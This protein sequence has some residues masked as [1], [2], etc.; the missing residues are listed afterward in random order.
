[1]ILVQFFFQKIWNLSFSHQT[2]FEPPALTPRYMNLQKF[3][4][5]IFRRKEQGLSVEYFRFFIA[6]KMKELHWFLWNF[7]QDLKLMRFDI[8][9]W[10]NEVVM[11]R[12][13]ENPIQGFFTNPNPTQSQ[14]WP[15]PN[16]WQL[17]CDPNRT[18]FFL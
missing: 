3:S 15:E 12:V 14:T 4:L 10:E 5:N 11:G 18:H 2:F 1:M 6:L 8:W 17:E 7:Y 16:M 9:F 13:P